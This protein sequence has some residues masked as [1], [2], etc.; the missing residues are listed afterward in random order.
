[1]HNNLIIHRGGK[2]FFVQIFIC[3]GSVRIKLTIQLAIWKQRILLPTPTRRVKDWFYINIVKKNYLICL[4]AQ[5]EIQS[6]NQKGSHKLLF[7][8]K[9][10]NESPL[11]NRLDVARA[12]L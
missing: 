7:S 3:K 5:S 2:F 11:F 4:M 6:H 10:F 1:M 9:I 12:V 8:F